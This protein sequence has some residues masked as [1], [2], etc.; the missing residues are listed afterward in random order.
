MARFVTVAKPADIKPGQMKSFSVDGKRVLIANVAG[1][2]FAAQDLC[3]HDGGTLSDGELV[4]GQIECPRH[5]GR[6]DAQT[7]KVTALPPMLPIQ[8]LPVHIEDAEIQ[9]AV[10]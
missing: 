5:G 9:I 7:G 4:D 3:T 6:F 8:T 2:F 10:E 1:T